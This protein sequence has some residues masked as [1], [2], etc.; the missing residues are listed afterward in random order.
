MTEAIGDGV[1]HGLIGLLAAILL[2]EFFV[3]WKGNR[4]VEPGILFLL[5]IATVLGLGAGTAHFALPDADGHVA[6]WPAGC[7][8]GLGVS[9]SLA[10]FFKRRHRDIHLAEMDRPTCFK[11][12]GMKHRRHAVEG[13]MQMG[14]TAMLFLATAS[15]GAGTFSEK[16][17]ENFST[18]ELAVV[19]PKN[20][21]T[22]APRTMAELLAQVDSQ[23]HSEAE[24]ETAPAPVEP[25]PAAPAA[26]EP[27]PEPE[28][29]ETETAP[30]EEDAM[31]ASNDAAQPTLEPM[32]EA[33]SPEEKPAIARPKNIPKNVF[34]THIQPVLSKN[35]FSCHGAKEQKGGL[36]LDTAEGIRKG[37]K[38]GSAIVAGEPDK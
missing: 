7:L 14:Y 30:S 4:E 38:S 18:P 10:F 36:R 31:V 21:V 27:E 13:N 1:V 29:E 5:A 15:L 12:I 26:P 34:A 33:G 37:G 6:H 32:A 35:C 17:G 19:E 2:L 8:L 25:T 11:T 23:V 9:A 28:P 20:P 22:G 16:V 24:P 3:R